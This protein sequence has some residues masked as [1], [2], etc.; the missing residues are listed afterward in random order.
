MDHRNAKMTGR[1]RR[2]CIDGAAFK[3]NF[4]FVRGVNARENFTKGAFA[5]AVFADERVATAAFDFKTHRIQRED[6][7]ET[8]GDVL[9]SEEGLAMV[10]WRVVRAASR[11]VGGDAVHAGF[12]FLAGDVWFI[13]R[14]SVEFQA[15][16]V[17]P[18]DKVFVDRKTGIQVQTVKLSRPWLF[19]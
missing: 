12:G 10:S 17:N 18:D 15:R 5:R 14:P 16:F 6:A 7:G 9:K 3:L 4:A 19:R 8:F 11:A 13:H 2:G 1:E